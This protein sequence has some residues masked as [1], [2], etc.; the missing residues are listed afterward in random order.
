M[1]QSPVSA[2]AGKEGGKNRTINGT[3]EG[4]IDGVPSDYFQLSKLTARHLL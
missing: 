3:P 1:S 4:W 2:A